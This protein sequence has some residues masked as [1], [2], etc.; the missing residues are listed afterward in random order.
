MQVFN[1][2]WTSAWQLDM[3]EDSIEF[4]NSKPKALAIYAFT[5]NEQFKRRIEAETSSGSLVFNDAVIQVFHQ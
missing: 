5:K 1:S 4:I 2:Q 3:V